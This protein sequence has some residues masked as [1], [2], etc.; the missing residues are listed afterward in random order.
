MWLARLPWG[1]VPVRSCY[2]ALA[3]TVGEFQHLTTGCGSTKPLFSLITIPKLMSSP[4]TNQQLSPVIPSEGLSIARKVMEDAVAFYLVNGGPAVA[5]EHIERLANEL[6][7]YDDSTEAYRDVMA[8]I[9]QAEKA[10]QQRADERNQQQ[11]RD[12]F[13]TMMGVIKPKNTGENTGEPTPLFPK[14]STDKAMLM[15]QRLRQA[16]YIDEHYQ[17]VNLSRT[18]LALLAN[19]MSN[20]LGIYD[21]WKTFERLWNKKNLRNELNKALDQHKSLSFISL[22]KN[23]FADIQ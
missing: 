4:M 12:L 1:V 10:E 2:S 21:K 23:I 13:L 20:R 18:Q 19:E 17:P 11:Q 22:M 7:F 9:S 5:R 6:K 16:G 14:L 3:S 8:M 15:W